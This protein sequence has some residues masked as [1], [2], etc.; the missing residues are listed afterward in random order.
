MIGVSANQA[1]NGGAVF[2]PVTTLQA[3]LGSP[4]A[5]NS[6]WITSTS[7]ATRR[8][9]WDDDRI[10]DTLAAHGHQVVTLVI[11][12]ARERQ[13]AANATITSRS[14]CSAC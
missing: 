14:R 2:L 10:E 9:R 11:Y 5:V 13:V 1:D 7:G 6:Y 4:G 12:D 3:V 8:D